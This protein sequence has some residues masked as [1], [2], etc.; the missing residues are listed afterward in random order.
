RTFAINIRMLG[1]SMGETVR[2][3]YLLCRIA[4]TIEDGWPGDR[5]EIER[6]FDALLAAI[7]GDITA[8]ESLAGAARA[9]QGRASRDCIALGENA[10]AV[11]RCFVALAPADRLDVAEAV[12]V[13]ASGMRRYA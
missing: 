4:D 7:E 12:T 13:L 10:P 1:G 11:L 6:R 2:I 5:R 8:V 9:L 3:A